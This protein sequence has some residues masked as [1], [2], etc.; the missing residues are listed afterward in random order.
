[1]Y[2]YIFMYV[3]IC[4]R[5]PANNSIVTVTYCYYL[6]YLENNRYTLM[7]IELSRARK[8]IMNNQHI[9]TGCH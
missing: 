3:N 5:P 9:C 6:K 8:Y 4:R 2:M 1:M 7:H